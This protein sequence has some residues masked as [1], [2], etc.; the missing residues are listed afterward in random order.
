MPQES[1]LNLLK[2][3]SMVTKL[4]GLGGFPSFQA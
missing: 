2:K 4:S 3:N 1:L